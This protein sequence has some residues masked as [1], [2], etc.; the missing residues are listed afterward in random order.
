MVL[1]GPKDVMME[2]NRVFWGLKRHKGSKD[3]W[4]L[5]V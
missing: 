5:K 4:G 1:K 2:G 3:L